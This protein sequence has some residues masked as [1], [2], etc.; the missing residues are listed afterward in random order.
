M[1]CLS[2]VG[3]YIRINIL[4]ETETGLLMEDSTTRSEPGINK[5]ALLILIVAGLL[6]ATMIAVGVL[7]KEEEHLVPESLV[8]YVL[9]DPQKIDPFL[10]VDFNGNEYGIGQLEGKWTFIFFGYI[11]CPDVCPVTLANLAMVFR[12]L[13]SAGLPMAD[14]Q[15]LFISVDPQ[16]DTPAVLKGYVPGF[17]DR[18]LGVTGDKSALD[19]FTRQFGALYFL[20]EEDGAGNYLVTHNSSL[21]LVDPKVRQFARF[22]VPHLPDQ[23]ADAFIRIYK[24]YGDAGQNGTGEEE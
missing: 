18:F 8:E 12:Q 1:V 16:R 24:H 15:V 6:V 14:L 5:T 11:S 19:S 20:D 2:R 3:E 23:I 4:W 13:E 21:F 9:W 7:Q 10:L 17:D 22:A